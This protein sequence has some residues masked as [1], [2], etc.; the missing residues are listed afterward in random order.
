MKAP[1][2]V[3]LGGVVVRAVCLG[4]W[5]TEPCRCASPTR[6][7]LQTWLNDEGADEADHVALKRIVAAEDLLD[8]TDHASPS[9][10]NSRLICGSP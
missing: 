3:P 6:A 8:A 9:T 5:G 2:P 1:S 7:S 10:I 4:S